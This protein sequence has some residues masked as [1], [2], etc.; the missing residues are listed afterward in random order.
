MDI[1]RP[2]IKLINDVKIEPDLNQIS[3]E[4]IGWVKSGEQQNKHYQFKSSLAVDGIDNVISILEELE[5]GHLQEIDF[6]EFTACPGGC[7]GGPLN[8]ENR[9][10]AQV[11]LEKISN[12][13]SMSSIEESLS[14]EELLQNYKEGEYNIS[15]LIKPRPNSK[16]DNDIKKA[17]NKLDSLERE[18]SRL[19]GL[20]CTACG[21]PSCR[22]LAEDIVNGLAKREDCIILLKKKVKR[23]SQDIMGLVKSEEI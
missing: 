5:R 18:E 8:V 4:G 19:P 17:I 1:Y 16:L 21:A 23:L 7:I 13:L 14:T 3:K 6:F 22:G 2:L 12:Q 20:D 10:I 15:K 11:A 9:F